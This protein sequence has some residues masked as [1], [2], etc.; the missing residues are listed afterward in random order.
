MKH[1]TITDLVG[2]QTTSPEILKILTC[3]LSHVPDRFAERM[4]EQANLG[5][6]L[7]REHSFWPFAGEY[8][9]VLFAPNRAAV[10]E[11]FGGTD[12]P[13]DIARI[14]VYAGS[15]GCSFVLF[16]EDGDELP[17]FTLYADNEQPAAEIEEEDDEPEA[18]QFINHYRC[19]DCGE[20]WTDTS[21]YTNNDHCPNCDL[22]DIEPYKSEDL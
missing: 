8:G 12:C 22:G 14:L 19:P 11:D 3:S 21:P 15:L 17:G 5:R 18:D 20:E 4:R 13:D 2:T 7:G 16:D 10:E 9:I 1:R 6:S